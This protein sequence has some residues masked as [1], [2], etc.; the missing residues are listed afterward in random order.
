MITEFNAILAEIP[1][2]LYI[3][4]KSLKNKFRLKL[5]SVLIEKGPLSLTAISKSMGKENGYILGHIK[6]MELAG[7]IQNFIKKSE[8]TKEY[9]Y[10]ETTRM[11]NVILEPFVNKYHEFHGNNKKYSISANDSLDENVLSDLL[12]IFKALANKTRF[13]LSLFLLNHDSLS[14]STIVDV[15][16]KSK[17]SVMKHLKKLKICGF[18]QNFFKKEHDSSEY[19]FYKLTRFGKLLVTQLIESYN[20]FYA[21]NES[22]SLDSQESE[23][24][25]RDKHFEA[26]C[27]SWVLPNEDI[28]CWIN[29]LSTEVKKIWVKM[30]ES[31][32]LRESCNL[33][34]STKENGLYFEDLTAKNVNYISLVFFSEIPLSDNKLN[35]EKLE[36]FAYN[37]QQEI[38][39]QEQLNI[40][41]IKPII[42]LKVNFSKTSESS[43]FFD[44]KL[45]ISEG[46]QVEIPGIQFKIEDHLGRAVN[47]TKKQKDITEMMENVPPG[48]KLQNMIGEFRLS[49]EGIFKF[50]F[51][52][53]YF[54]VLRNEY[55]SNE[56]IITIDNT[57][58]FEGSFNYEYSQIPEAIAV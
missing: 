28:L 52:V 39:E 25:S 4:I 10:Y 32:Q 8:K 47:I 5:A 48:V 31:L 51:R 24:Q 34:F 19:S 6:K 1:E 30:S 58:E 14:F 54:D 9:S 26:T 13:T 42:K 43:G 2:N 44:I 56:E 57:R 50:Y 17:T 12:K 21:P 27:S 22:E 35:H 40:D 49:G 46:I 53:Q 15:T 20:L 3:L 36:I 55:Y 37:D 29:I 18:I 33:K 41:V 16:K 45:S 7:V 23:S 38:I 11:L